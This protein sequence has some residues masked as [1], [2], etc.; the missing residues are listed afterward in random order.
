MAFSPTKAQKFKNRESAYRIKY[1]SPK[2]QEILRE[3]CRQR[4]RENRM[5]LF[6]K[7]RL[8]LENNSCSVQERLMN[9]VRMEFKRLAT[10]EE[11]MDTD[12][13]LS[14]EE[15]IELENQIIYEQEQWILQE[16]EKISQDELEYLIMFAD[17]DNSRD[18]FC[19]VCLKALLIEEL[20]EE[21][22]VCVS[23]KNCKYR[24]N[25][26][27]L[28]DVKL[29]ITRSF[30]AHAF[31]CATSPVFM[32]ASGYNRTHRIHMVCNV[33]STSALIC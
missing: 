31:N 19:P 11:T 29:S 21:K 10:K 15:A 9:I 27:K 20:I 26:R 30:N 16:Y 22:T 5:E 12:E 14:I 13:P 7:R 32:V 17:S 1:G 18:V 28:K 24:L 3:N 33:C 25:N 23:C 6:N 4:M 8:G 2:M